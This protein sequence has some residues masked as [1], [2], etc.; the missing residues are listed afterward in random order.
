MKLPVVKTS[1][2]VTI[3]FAIYLFVL[4]FFVLIAAVGIGRSFNLFKKISWWF[5]LVSTGGILLSPVWIT[6]YGFPSLR[7]TI[8]E[9]G[10]SYIMRKCTYHLN[11][12]EIRY[13]ILYPDRYGRFTKNCF[14]CFVADE[15]P[16]IISGREQFSDRV[17]GVQYRKGL[18]EYIGRYC[19]KPIQGLEYLQRK[20]NF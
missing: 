5:L 3:Y 18:P 6:K 15:F 10:V 16:P 14:I 4:P 9:D 13:V 7:F 8:D 1:L 11:W 20:R 2:T 19:D 12:D 17:F